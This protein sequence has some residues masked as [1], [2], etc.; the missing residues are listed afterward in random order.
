[1]DEKSEHLVAGRGFDKLAAPDLVEQY[2][3]TRGF[4][5][6]VPRD[7]AVV[8]EGELVTFLRSASGRDPV[9]S[10]WLLDCEQGRE[11]LLADARLLGGDSEL[12]LP[13]E[14]LSRRERVREVA[15][16]IVA[17]SVDEA[18]ETA[19][20]ALDGALWVV[21]V[22]DAK[23]QRL[24]AAGPVFDPRVDPTGSR[25][26]YV[27]G[28][29]LRAIEVDGTNDHVVASGTSREVRWGEAEFVAAEE[30]GRRT[31]Y[32]WSPDGAQLLVAMTDSSDV[33]R[34]Y[35][36]VGG[37]QL[38]SPREVVYPLTGSRNVKVLLY[39]VDPDGQAP[40]VPVRWDSSE[41]EYL[42]RVDWTAR[43]LLLNL[44][45]RDQK[46]ADA[47]MVDCKTGATTV[48]ISAQEEVWIDIVPG[49]PSV[50]PDGRIISVAESADTVRICV[51]GRPTTPPGL[52]VREVLAVDA[53]GVLFS[54]STDPCDTHV[55]SLSQHG[56][57]Q[58]LTSGASVSTARRGHGTTVMVTHTLE[59]V[60]PDVHVSRDGRTWPV[61]V[62]CE[63][64]SREVRPTLRRLGGSSLASALLLPSWHREGGG[65][66]PVLM[67]PYGGAAAQRVTSDLRN[68]VLSQWFAEQGFAVLVADG[69]GT[70]GRGSAWSRSIRGDILSLPLDDQVAALHEAASLMPELDLGRV[71]IRGWSFGGV[72][73]A[74]A[75][76]RRPDVF[77]AAIAGAPDF[78][79]RLY[80]THS[81]E[82]YLGDPSFEPD[83]YDRSSLVTA[84]RD[85]TRPLM[86]I[87]GFAD[88]NVMMTHSVAFS[89]AL[90][91]RGIRHEAYYV[92][93]LTHV[94]RDPDTLR[95]ILAMEVSFLRQTLHSPDGGYSVRQ[96]VPP[97]GLD[98]YSAPRTP[99]LHTRNRLIG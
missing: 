88:D 16:G 93:A 29:T 53:A 96:V 34:Y 24:P 32:W 94:R 98:G 30:M 79:S 67:D 26:A 38:D 61:A 47:L 75:V 46:R 25:V 28:R 82:H 89:A 78:D 83:G 48:A 81:K 44:E 10:L 72:L 42:V 2:A 69:H 21:S 56:L 73:A 35:A 20:F 80:D 76:L 57:L 65:R 64:P 84:A 50:L 39:L 91:K 8:R 15:T 17:Y 37:S 40:L 3:E 51:D 9:T 52:Q 49:A 27:S 58:Q 77:R 36:S 71:G 68:Y 60:V 87:H 45:S 1:M 62:L 14:E 66:L 85:L 6:G 90:T 74:A 13:I 41:Y 12:H 97:A 86:L 4:A 11:I 43:G 19:S 5:L 95:S 18:G 54:G 59:S 55:W 31:G 22:S 70:P 23:V 33:S 92:P 7:F 99:G 63:T